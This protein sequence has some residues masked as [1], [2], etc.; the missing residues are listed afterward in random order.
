M[1]KK[2][3]IYV[4]ANDTYYFHT[5][6]NVQKDDC[7]AGCYRDV[8]YIKHLLFGRIQIDL[9]DENLYLTKHGYVTFNGGQ[10]PNCRLILY[11]SGI[12]EIKYET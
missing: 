8:C 10:E 1:N 6:K 5:P 7:I 4:K 2:S 3:I 12:Q 9:Y 11:P